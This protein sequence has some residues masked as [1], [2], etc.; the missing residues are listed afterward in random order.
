MVL[1]TVED[2]LTKIFTLGL[3]IEKCLSH[4]RP[5]VL[6]FIDYEQAFDSADK[7]AL[8]KVLSLSVAP[9]K[10][11]KVISAMYKK[12][13]AAG[14]EGSEVSIWFCINPLAQNIPIWKQALKIFIPYTLQRP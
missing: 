4:Q 12:N 3:I 11:I 2:A 10:Y 14:K 1:G 8:G 13:I 5:L 6:N 7:R 9:D